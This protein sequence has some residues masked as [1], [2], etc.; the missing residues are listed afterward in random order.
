VW[1]R[2]QRPACN[3][4]NRHPSA[5]GSFDLAKRD[6]CRRHIGGKDL[7]IRKRNAECN[8]VSAG[9]AEPAARGRND[10]VKTIVIDEEQGRVTSLSR[11][12]HPLAQPANMAAV[13]DSGSNRCLGGKL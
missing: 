11:V 6:R 3:R 5:L 13:A 7:S 1:A 4:R 2:R 9:D 12:L 10:L 8:G